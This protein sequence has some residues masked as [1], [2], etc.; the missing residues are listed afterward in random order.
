MLKIL[1]EPYPLYIEGRTMWPLMI[2]IGIFIFL[3]LAIFQP[4]EIYQITSRSKYYYLLGFGLM[5]TISLGIFHIILPSQLPKIFNEN[6]WTV[7]KQVLYF[8]LTSS[9]ILGICYI[10]FIW[11]NSHN[12]DLRDFIVFYLETFA[13]GLFPIFGIVMANYIRLL[14]KHQFE[15]SIPTATSDSISPSSVQFVLQEAGK[16]SLSLSS[17]ELLFVK[18]A[19]NYVE[20]HFIKEDTTKV[21]VLRTTL[22]EV[23]KSI[24]S[25]DILRCHR[26]YIVNTA[27][28]KEITGNAQGFQLH[29]DLSDSIIPVARSKGK[30]FV[31]RIKV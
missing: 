3:F 2:G 17:E 18:S 13:L 20:I 10:Y 31:S 12:L 15:P 7:G 4:F 8:L 6:K 21:S 23:E 26:S 30:A 9:F 24:C 11:Y 28:V 22:S 14:K 5:T 27:H 29:F 1:K 16:E 25:E 19:G